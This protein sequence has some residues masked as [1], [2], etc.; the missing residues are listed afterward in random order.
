MRQI[1]GAQNNLSESARLKRRS[2][3]R[4]G[5]RVSSTPEM[6]GGEREGDNLAASKKHWMTGISEPQVAVAQLVDSWC[7]A[8]AGEDDQ[9]S[10][11]F[12]D[13]E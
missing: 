10:S 5:E 4:E 12:G 1:K 13:A 7:G 2:K 8:V 6:T 11:G 9:E 3:Q